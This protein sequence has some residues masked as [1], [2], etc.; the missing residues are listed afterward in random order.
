VGVG[1]VEV[2]G[3][4]GEGKEKERRRKGEEV[5]GVGVGGGVVVVRGE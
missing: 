5:G 1:G 2:G 3:E 4:Y